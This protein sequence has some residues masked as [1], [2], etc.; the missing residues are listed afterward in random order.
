M[1]ERER[2]FRVKGIHWTKNSR[3]SQIAEKNSLYSRGFFSN[4]LIIWLKGRKFLESKVSTEPKTQGI[5]KLAKKTVFIVEGFL[6]NWLIVRRYAIEFLESK[7]STEPKT[8]GIH[9][10]AKKIVFIVGGFL[11]NWLSLRVGTIEFLESEVSTSDPNPS[12]SQIGQKNLLIIRVFPNWLKEPSTRLGAIEFLDSK[13]R[14]E[15]KRASPNSQIAPEMRVLGPKI[16]RSW[17]HLRPQRSWLVD[18]MVV[19]ARPPRPVE[20]YNLKVRV[21]K[22]NRK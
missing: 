6:S 3:N 17:L 15:P 5:H 22:K 10:S 20:R 12:S 13:G 21:L 7:V 4:R 19:D 9:K 2:I 8:R 18:K 1:V 11:S 16:V 14:A